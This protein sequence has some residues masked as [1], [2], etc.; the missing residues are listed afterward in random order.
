MNIAD[1]FLLPM[2]KLKS[3]DEGLPTKIF[4]YQALGKPIIC[5]SN[6]ESAQYIESTKSGIVVSP[7]NP[8]AL[9]DGVSRLYQDEVLTWELGANGQKYVNQNMTVEKIGERVSNLF[10]SHGIVSQQ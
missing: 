10:I 3:A 5:C 9:A 6:G 7:G 1:I 4:E 2:K 8:K